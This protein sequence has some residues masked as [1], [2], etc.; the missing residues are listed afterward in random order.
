MGG[1]RKNT[2]CCVAQ[3]VYYQGSG[4][5]LTGN[6]T[7]KRINALFFDSHS[8][9]TNQYRCNRATLYCIFVLVVVLPNRPHSCFQVRLFKIS[10]MMLVAMSGAMDAGQSTLSQGDKKVKDP[11]LH[12]AHKVGLKPKTSR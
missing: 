12:L 8:K 10:F 9:K 5:D 4:N 3:Q 1:S 7:V 6:L 11:P 2:L